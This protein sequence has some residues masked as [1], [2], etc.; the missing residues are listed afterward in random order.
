MRD[1]S[2]AAIDYGDVVRY[3]HLNRSALTRGND[4]SRVGE[5]QR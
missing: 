1:Q 2:T 3:S 4:S 5:I